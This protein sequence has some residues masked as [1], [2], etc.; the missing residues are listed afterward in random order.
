MECYKNFKFHVIG[1]H[2]NAL[3]FSVAKI[4]KS[5]V[6]ELY[7]ITKNW[8]NQSE[9]STLNQCIFVM[10][11]QKNESNSLTVL[12]ETKGVNAL[13]NFMPHP[14]PQGGWGNTGDLT[15][16]GVKF[17]TPGVKS[18]VKSPPL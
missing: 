17:P 3:L 11:R 8:C 4:W 6:V 7:R 12:K 14:P 5:S 18:A 13:V 2:V 10:L 9:R 16:L 1:V 15:N